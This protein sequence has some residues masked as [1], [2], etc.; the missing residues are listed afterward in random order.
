M[1]GDIVEG[2]TLDIAGVTV[3]D[4]VDETA[5]VDV[6]VEEKEGEEEEEEEEEEGGWDPDVRDDVM[7]IPFFFF[8]LSSF[9]L[10]LLSF[11]ALGRVFTTL[12]E[13]EG[14]G[15]IEGEEEE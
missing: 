9:P 5:V 6:E 3:D 11:I 7:R 14:E 10:A 15:V 1:D 13:R 8:F 12:A 4:E 2:V